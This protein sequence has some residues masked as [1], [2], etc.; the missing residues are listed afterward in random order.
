MKYSIAAVVA[1]MSL[2]SAAWARTEVGSW[3]PNRE[4]IAQAANAT[5]SHDPAT[6]YVRNA[7]SC[8]GDQARAVWGSQQVLLGY[9]CYDNPN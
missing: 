7:N 6:L 9:A 3:Q 2:S 4:E 1:L 5:M 8:A